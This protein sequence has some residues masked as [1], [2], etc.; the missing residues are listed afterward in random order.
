M[1]P[2]HYTHKEKILWKSLCRDYYLAIRTFI[3]PPCPALKK[4]RFPRFLIA[5]GTYPV[6]RLIRVAGRVQ[7]IH[8]RC[9]S[10]ALKVVVGCLSFPVFFFYQLLSK[11]LVEAQYSLIVRLNAQQLGLEIYDGIRQSDLHFLNLDFRGSI[12]KALGDVRDGFGRC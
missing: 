11:L 2:T 4:D 1:A 9:S 12:R 6:W 3:F 7:S 5:I 10:K 8:K